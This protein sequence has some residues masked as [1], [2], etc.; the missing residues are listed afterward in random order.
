M[1]LK[2]RQ[3]FWEITILILTLSGCRGIPGEKIQAEMN[4]QTNILPITTGTFTQPGSVD[5]YT[6]E[7]WGQE[8]NSMK[9]LGINLWIYQWVGDSKNKTTIYPTRLT[10]YTQT[11]RDDQVEL[12]LSFAQKYGLQVFLGLVFNDDWWQKEGTDRDWLLHEAQEMNAVADELYASY[13]TR[14]PDTFAGWYINW[15]MD[16]FAGYNRRAKQ[17]ENMI[18]AL[19]LVSDHLEGLNP[20]LPSS[21]A[22]FFNAAGGAAAQ[23]Y[24]EFCYEVMSKTGV[25]ILMLQDGI[26]V[27]HATLDQLPEWYQQVCA[28]VR[29]AGKL[30]WSDL[31]NFATDSDGNLIPAPTERV[32]QQHQIA[33]QYVDRIV[34]FSFISYMS[35]N[36]PA[37]VPYYKGFQEYVNGLPGIQHIP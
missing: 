29:A 17:K 7:M 21:I 25:D 11:T 4:Q 26:G 32:I 36:D 5:N 35:P 14:Y 1:R 18:E 10:G 19:Q 12:A 22:P 37:H 20:S 3:L 2:T 30:C 31:E 8:F 28:G 33:A 34:T 24:G 16:N 23:A 15:E 27:E 9:E 6:P 13:F